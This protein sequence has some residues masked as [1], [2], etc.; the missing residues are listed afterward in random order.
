VVAAKKN[1]YT[2]ILQCCFAR[3]IYARTNLFNIWTVLYGRGGGK[4]FPHRDSD[5]AIVFHM[6]AKRRKFG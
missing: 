3:L 5:V 1:R 6:I 4:V 2:L